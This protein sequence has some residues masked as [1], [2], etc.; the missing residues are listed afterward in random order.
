MG[1]IQGKEKKRSLKQIGFTGQLKGIWIDFFYFL[2]NIAYQKA[3]RIISLFER[4][5]TIQIEIGCSPEKT[6]VIHN[7]IP[8]EQYET[9]ADQV[10]NRSLNEPARIGAIVRIVPIKDI[11]TML[12]AFALASQ[13]LPDIEFML[14]GPVDEDPDYYQECLQFIDF[15]KLKNIVFTGRVDVK[16]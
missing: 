16:D 6:K 8:L 15:L 13:R 9:I 11:K 10:Q 14:L 4:S 2:S 5:R 3:N 1:F 7:G 12:Q